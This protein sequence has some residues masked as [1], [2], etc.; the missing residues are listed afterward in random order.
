MPHPSPH[1]PARPATATPARPTA[2][3]LATAQARTVTRVVGLL[4][5][6]TILA[7]AATSAVAGFLLESVFTGDSVAPWL[8]WLAAG[9]ALIAAIAAYA[10][11][12]YGVRQARAEEGRIRAQLL[13]HFLVSFREGKAASTARQIALMTDSVERVTDYKQVYWGSA[14]ASIVAPVVIVLYLL[15]L[16]PL[17]GAG[18]LLALPFVPLSVW[19]FFRYF[20]KT[21]GNS[22]AKRE[23][24]SI[25]YLDALRNLTPIRLYGAGQR[26]EAA[27][28]GRGEANRQAVMKLLAANQLLIV[29][30]DTLF[31]LLLIAFAAAMISWRATEGALTAGQALSAALVLP[32]LLEPLAQV[33]GFFYIG[34]GGKASERVLNRMLSSGPAGGGHPGGHPGA[35]AGGHHGSTGKHPGRHTNGGHP[36]AKAGWR[37]GGQ[38]GK[39]ETA[40]PSVDNA[41]AE[42]ALNSE[43]AISVR[44]LH[45]DFGRGP[46]LTNLNVDVPVGARVAFVGASGA[47]KSTLLNLL[48]GT[49]ALQ[50]GAVQ[51]SGVSFRKTPQKAPLAS[52]SVSQSTW[53][54]SGTIEDNLRM[55]RP[56]ATDAQLWEALESAYLAHDV[57]ALEHGLQTPVGEGG[58]ALSGGQAQ[59][60][61]L[62]R[63]LLSGR[64]VIFLDEPTSQIDRDSE[65]KIL[66]AL[67]NLSTET[68]LVM[69][70]HRTSLLDIADTVYTLD[71][72]GLHSLGG[73]R[74]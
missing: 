22:R 12:T 10:E 46:V 50:T 3:P 19:L 27:L 71:A 68:T 54:F 34:M 41:A 33:A 43:A 42:T 14:V 58:S 2:A 17:L 35:K 44:Y 60:L 53:L 52:V 6:L 67:G 36:G 31:Y 39:P 25:A 69:V 16:D 11:I 26:I 56:D 59:R 48:R 38:P 55:A 40:R 66:Q 61:S 64:K 18:M 51:V 47:G 29:V 70:T 23:A 13:T 63:A 73:N 62:A 24:L 32:L 4:R 37:P 57:R 9:C 72:S 15:V 20:R 74:D 8:W 1:F 49:L 5:A 45:H 7:S 65:G 28:K 21:S 30:M